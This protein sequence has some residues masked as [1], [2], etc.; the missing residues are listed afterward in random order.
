MRICD[1]SLRKTG[2]RKHEIM[3]FEKI[4]QSISDSVM[5]MDVELFEKL[6]EQCV[7]VLAK[8][9]KIIVSGVGKNTPVCEKFVDSMD[10][11]GLNALFINSFNALHG[12]VGKIKNED[13]I[14]ILSKSGETEEPI[15]L[16]EYLLKQR[17]TLRWLLT[18]QPESRLIN[19][20]EQKLILTLDDEGDLWNI[21]P[22]NSTTVSLIVLQELVI[23][24]ARKMEVSVNDFKRNHP[25]GTIGKML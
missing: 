22:I 12:A 19:E 4:L 23:S 1:I 24:I 3:N 9:G 7:E 21:M 17:K 2:N 10:S 13:L 18:F 6:T 8:N 5:S 25:G 20:I 16:N 15:E 11:H 14:L